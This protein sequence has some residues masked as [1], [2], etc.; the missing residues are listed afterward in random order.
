MYK[1]QV[2]GF[3]CRE[4]ELSAIENWSKEG[5]LQFL[6]PD[7]E[8]KL[9]IDRTLW[10][11]VFVTNTTRVN[12]R[13][14]GTAPGY[15]LETPIENRTAESFWEDLE[16]MISFLE[17]NSEEYQKPTWVIALTIVESPKYVQRLQAYLDD[18]TTAPHVRV[19]VV[20]QP[21]VNDKWTFLGYDV[22]DSGPT[23]WEGLGD[24]AYPDEIQ[25]PLKE[26]W[27][28]HLNKYHLFDDQELALEYCDWQEKAENH[29][30]FVYGLYQTQQFPVEQSINE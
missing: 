1:Q 30:Y 4:I 18:Y 5:R 13:S 27:G 24:G 19:P 17:R 14:V 8:R 3:D 2:I 28:K 16:A 15:R 10:N 11:S 20:T 21:E 9:T 6:R 29:Y 25:L 22:Q 7:I 26:K 23:F 12:G